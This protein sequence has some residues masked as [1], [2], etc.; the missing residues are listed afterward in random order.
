LKISKVKKLSVLKFDRYIYETVRGD[1][2]AEE[3]AVVWAKKHGVDTLYRFDMGHGIKWI[4]N[5][6]IEKEENEAI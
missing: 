4:I 1:K 3:K 2:D 6:D 5:A